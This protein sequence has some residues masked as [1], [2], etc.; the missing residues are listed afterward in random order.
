MIFET[1]L[2]QKNINAETFLWDNPEKFKELKTIFNQIHPESFTMQKK[3]LLN[4]L[5]RKYQLKTF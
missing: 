3:F 5:R 2:E 1:Y 4:K